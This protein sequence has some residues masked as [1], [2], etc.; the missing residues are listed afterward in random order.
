MVEES[1]RAISR[2][3]EFQ[4]GEQERKL[5]KV[6]KSYCEQNVI[7]WFSVANLPVRDMHILY[8]SLLSLLP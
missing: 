7:S 6:I 3:E 4:R 8:I 1:V 2:D 5:I